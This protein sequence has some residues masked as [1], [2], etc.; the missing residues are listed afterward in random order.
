MRDVALVSLDA[1]FL[2]KAMTVSGWPCSEAM[3]TSVDPSFVR[4]ITEALNFSA[5]RSTTGVNPFSAATWM[6]VRSRKGRR[7]RKG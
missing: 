4:S 3:C 7:R 1:P 6:G 5:S 2:R